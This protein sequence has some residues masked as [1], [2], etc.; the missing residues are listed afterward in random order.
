MAV[1]IASPTARRK[2]EAIREEA[3]KAAFD[4]AIA[5]LGGM[6]VGAS[7]PSPPAS[8]DADVEE[9]GKLLVEGRVRLPSHVRITVIAEVEEIKSRDFGTTST[10]FTH[11][12][13]QLHA[14]RMRPMSIQASLEAGL[15]VRLN[16]S[17]LWSESAYR[18]LV[19]PDPRLR[20]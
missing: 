12:A 8:T 2:E 7:P 18:R 3:R 10:V 4:L 17:W 16:G 20:T 19:P 15:L 14:H 9:V 11:L 1:L 5:K 13:D 6:E